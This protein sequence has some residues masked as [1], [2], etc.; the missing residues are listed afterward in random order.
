M[1]ERES[2]PAADIPELRAPLSVALERV[3]LRRREGGPTV[4][5]WRLSIASGVGSGSVCLVDMPDGNS[6]Y[7]GEGLFLGWSQVRM[8]ALYEKLRPAPPGAQPDPG[9]FG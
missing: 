9:Q 1:I 8:H 7:R 4:S 6:L 5:G 3:S 2:S